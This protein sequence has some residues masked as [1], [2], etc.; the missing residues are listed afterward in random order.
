MHESCL[1]FDVL[2]PWG[3]AEKNQFS[4]PNLEQN[5]N[6]SQEFFCLISV[7]VGSNPTTDDLVLVG[8]L[9]LTITNVQ[10]GEF[11]ND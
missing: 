3:H 4:R 6:V 8:T 10:A 9:L 1:L 5:S 11:I 2:M 7:G